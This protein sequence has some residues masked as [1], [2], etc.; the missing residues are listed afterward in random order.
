MTVGVDYQHI[1]GKA[2]NRVIATGEDLGPMGDAHENEIAGYVDFRQDL[3]SWLTLDAGLRL[4]HHSQ[5]GTEWVPQGGL[6]FRLAGAA[7]RTRI[8][9]R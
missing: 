4:D 8:P 9:P 3:F 6:V 2:W 7:G 1:Y 5:S